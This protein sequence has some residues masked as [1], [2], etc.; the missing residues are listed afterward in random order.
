VRA[1]YGLK[2]AG[3]SWRE[4]FA[5]FL[6]N[7]LCFISCYKVDADVWRRPAT[8]VDDILIISHSHK[9]IGDSL[10]SSYRLKDLPATPTRYLGADI[11]RLSFIDGP[12]KYCWGMLSYSYVKE[13]FNTIEKDLD[14]AEK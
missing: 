8:N 4:H 13:T 9:A 2:S 1:L 7:Q 11:E 6:T 14:M 3:A 5:D 10:Q 12:D